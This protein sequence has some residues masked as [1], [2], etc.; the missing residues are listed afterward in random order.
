MCNAAACCT[1]LCHIA[2][3]HGTLHNAMTQKECPGMKHNTVA[4]KAALVAYHQCHGT[5]KSAMTSSKMPWHKKQ[6]MVQCC[7]PSWKAMA[8][9]TTPWHQSHC[10]RTKHDAAAQKQCHRTK[11]AV[12]QSNAAAH[13]T[14]LQHKNCATECCGGMHN[15]TA[16]NCKIQDATNHNVCHI[17][18]ATKAKQ[19]GC[20]FSL[21]KATKQQ[22]PQKTQQTTRP[23]QT[24]LRH[25]GGQCWT[26]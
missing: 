14:V 3:C 26:G 15:A 16:K 7:S 17:T 11:N 9:S 25:C 13:K 18:K 24:P 4:Q 1:M 2:P 20:F 23:K 21:Q 5:E 6:H 19:V 22:P 8:Q 12:A 10:H